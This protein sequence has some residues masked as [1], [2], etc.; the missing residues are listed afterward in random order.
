MILNQPLEQL[1]EASYNRRASV[2]YLQTKNENWILTVRAGWRSGRWRDVG[3][4][5]DPV[6]AGGG[7]GS[8][9]VRSGLHQGAQL[10][11][12]T[13]KVLPDQARALHGA[14]LQLHAERRSHPLPT[15][16]SVRHWS[17]AQTRINQF[18]QVLIW[19]SLLLS[20]KC[21]KTHTC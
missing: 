15:F 14:S 2:C 10:L 7:A 21:I 20:A 11:E 5:W 17:S 1:L 18:Y 6:H 8:H 9:V 12:H 16:F 4:S 3:G 19:V 13:V